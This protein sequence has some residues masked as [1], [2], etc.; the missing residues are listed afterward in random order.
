MNITLIGMA[1]AGKSFIGKKLAVRLGYTFLDIDTVIEAEYGMPLQSVLDSLGEEAFLNKESE[2]LLRETT[3]KDSYVFS[4]GGSV[5]YRKESM[6]H[7]KN[8]SRIVYLEVDVE[9]II[10]RVGNRPRGIV[11]L[12]E[13]TIG[14]LYDER[15]ALYRAWADVIQSGTDDADSTAERI[16]RDVDVR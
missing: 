5:I 16:V 13:K 12:A 3:G 8:I 15:V 7:L 10:A 1:G 2:I 11:G 4:P 14:E 9:T 6:G